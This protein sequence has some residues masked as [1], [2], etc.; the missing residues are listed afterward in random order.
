MIHIVI[1]M[2]LCNIVIF[3]MNKC[4]PI[5]YNMGRAE[6]T[7]LIG[8]RVTVINNENFVKLYQNKHTLIKSDLHF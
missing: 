3:E 6:T 7:Y 8:Y 2:S 5:I 4:Y 1:I